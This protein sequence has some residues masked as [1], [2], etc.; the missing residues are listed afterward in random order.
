MSTIL[1]VGNI[2]VVCARVRVG[3]EASLFV[4]APL[5]VAYT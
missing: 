2:E 4:Q 5:D 3:L 1:M